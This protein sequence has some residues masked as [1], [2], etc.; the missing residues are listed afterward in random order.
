MWKNRELEVMGD[1]RRVPDSRGSRVRAG[2]RVKLG[3]LHPSFAG[4]GGSEVLAA[5]QAAWLAGQGHEVALATLGWNAAR[6]AEELAAVELRLLPKRAFGDAFA[7]G[8][9]GKIRRRGA[10]L[11]QTLEGCDT[12]LAHTFPAELVTGEGASKA[13][14]VWYC[15]EPQRSLHMAAANPNLW[16]KVSGGLR[17]GAS[18]GER[19][20]HSR[21]GR[22]QEGARLRAADIQAVR[23]FDLVLANSA[24]TRDN[25]RSIFGEAVPMEVLPPMLRLPEP[26]PRP[27]GL[28][29]TAPGILVHSRLDALKNADTVMRAFARVQ[30]AHPGATL[31][32]V[33]DGPCRAELEALAKELGIT[34]RFHGYLPQA[35]LEVVY[36]AC[37]LFALLPFDEP[38]GMVFPEAAARGLLLVGPDH[39]GPLEILEG[40]EVG[41]ACDAF[42]PEAAAE[43]M[44]RSLALD[45]AAVDRRR[46][47]AEARC[48][49]RYA[50]SVLGPRLEAA[51]RA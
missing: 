47:S 43:A 33:G 44:L 10:R 11:R 36:R 42:D 4:T 2:N 15:H 5:A 26:I 25:A 34:P 21:L 8:K 1:P 49:E 51:L 39:G 20:F 18:L 40:G 7:F 9:L 14:K 24:F 13:R 35:E 28:D 45:D 12:I 50:E 48:R 38:F 30:R 37:D 19:W 31:H 27:S 41:Q 3:I 46:A 22:A 6:W 29:R 16:A 17:S 32:L 23:G